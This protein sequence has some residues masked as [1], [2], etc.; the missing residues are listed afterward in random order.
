MM[1]SLAFN[2]LAKKNPLPC[3]NGVPLNGQI[4]NGNPT[5]T[6]AWLI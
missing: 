3:D 4:K 1:A 2:E 5:F 6:P